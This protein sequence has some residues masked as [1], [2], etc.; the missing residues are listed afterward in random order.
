MAQ[1]PPPFKEPDYNKPKLFAGLPE[2]IVV[3]PE[4]LE[5]FLTAAVGQTISI[6]LGA[7][8]IEG[9]VTSKSDPSDLFLQSVVVRSTN[10]VGA[11]FTFSKVME[12]DGRLFYRGRLLSRHHSDAF[13][14][15]KVNG[16]YQLEKKH[17]LRILSE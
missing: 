14:L 6:R 4:Y 2:T 5:T 13:E 3:Q 1:Q 7:A 11:L 16:A 15:L 17:Q 12:K 8:R 10:Y 9:I